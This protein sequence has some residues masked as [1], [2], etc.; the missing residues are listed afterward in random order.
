MRACLLVA[1][2]A[3][4]LLGAPGVRAEE[5]AHDP[6]PAELARMVLDGN[7]AEHELVSAWLE[8]ASRGELRA[9]FI[10]LRTLRAQRAGPVAFPGAPIPLKKGNRGLTPSNFTPPEPSEVPEPT[11]GGSL[12]NIA[13][14]IIDVSV[15]DAAA[16]FGKHHPTAD[17]A[18]VILDEAE[19]RALLTRIAQQ[20]G[21]NVISAPRI[22]VYDRQQANVSVL[23]QI[24]FVQDYDVEQAKDGSSIADPIIGVIQEG[25]VI[26]LKP[27]LSANGTSVSLEF[28]GTFSALRKPI[29]EKKL[30]VG[31]GPDVT[32][33]LPQI[34]V[35]KITATAQVPDGG[36]V[37][38]GGSVQFQTGKNKRVERVA[39]VHVTKV[40]LRGG[41]AA[42]KR[43]RPAK[44]K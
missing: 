10:A 11:D 33:Q 27:T 34:D 23:N 4:F 28:T 24:S 17:A 15:G 38:L 36:W 32:I 14:R 26:D 20:P 3:L 19:A 44:K 25:I 43:A 40:D 21:A 39:L 13:V 41:L 30:S 16:L 2:L 6:T 8:Q 5:E 7:A 22:T 18:F 37:L 29:A 12:V 31:P 35:G 1:C 42:P 9:V